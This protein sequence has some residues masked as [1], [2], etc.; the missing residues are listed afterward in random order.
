MVS[1]KLKKVFIEFENLRNDIMNEKDNILI[2]QNKYPHI[3]HYEAKRTT[4]NKVIS[5]LDKFSYYIEE[6][7]KEEVLLDN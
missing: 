1:D 5:S 7:K 4:I 3:K 2:L 6:L